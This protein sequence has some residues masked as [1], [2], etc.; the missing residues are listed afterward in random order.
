MQVVNAPRAPRRPPHCLPILRTQ[1][2]SWHFNY[3]P[4]R[5]A[6]KETRELHVRLIPQSGVSRM[7]PRLVSRRTFRAREEGK[8]KAHICVWLSSFTAR[9]ALLPEKEFLRLWRHDIIYLLCAVHP[10]FSQYL[11]FLESAA[12]GPG[13]GNRM[14][15]WRVPMGATPEQKTGAPAENFRAMKWRQSHFHWICGR[16]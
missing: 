5:S 12:T 9:A 8:K 15:L 1:P 11:S 16:G 10:P 3:L 2:L 13:K 6:L 4:T 7:R 14:F